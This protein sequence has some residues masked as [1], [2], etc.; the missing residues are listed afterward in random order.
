MHRVFADVQGEELADGAFGGLFR[1]GG[2]HDFTIAGH[3]VVAFQDL[4][5]H[6]RRGHG[7][8]QLA[9]EGTFRVNFVELLGLGFGHPDAALGHDAQARVFDHGVDL[10]GQVALGRVGFDDRKGAFSHGLGVF[11]L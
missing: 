4:H 9:I 5:N 6:R 3:G 11:F 1:V 2:A 7:F 10:A 8:D